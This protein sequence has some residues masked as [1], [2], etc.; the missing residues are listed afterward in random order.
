METPD[1]ALFEDPRWET[2]GLLRETY[3]AVDRRIVLTDLRAAD[4]GLEELF[5][6]LTEESQRDD[7]PPGAA[8]PTSV[9]TQG[10]PA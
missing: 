9:P 1:D 10:A 7:L 2:F 3:L 6:T 5:L 4:G 8:P